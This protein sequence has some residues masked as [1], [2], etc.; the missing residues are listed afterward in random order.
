MGEENGA[1]MRVACGE[2][3]SPKDPE[4]QNFPDI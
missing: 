1:A 3:C 2:P 4:Y